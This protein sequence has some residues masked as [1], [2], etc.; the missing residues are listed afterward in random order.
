LA[1]S[2]KSAVRLLLAAACLCAP[3]SVSAGLATT[4]DELLVYDANQNAVDQTSNLAIGGIPQPGIQDTDTPGNANVPLLLIE[5]GQ[6]FQPTRP[7]PVVL[8]ELDL[9]IQAGMLVHNVVG[10]DQAT[11][12]LGFWSDADASNPTDVLAAFEAFG[13]GG[14]YNTVL[15]EVLPTAPVDVSAY[16][17][18]PL[19]ASFL[20]DGGVPEAS[21]FAMWLLLGGGGLAG[22]WWRQRRTARRAPAIADS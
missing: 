16:V 7:V 13:I 17:N 21:T 2:Q 19:S 8:A 4:T 1:H 12:N 6:D 5:P 14:L 22:R 11:G 9:L 3:S 10:V 15:V 20:S 18:L